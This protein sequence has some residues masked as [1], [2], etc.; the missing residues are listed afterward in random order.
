[1]PL[2]AEEFTGN[3][4][5]ELDI[6]VCEE[7]TESFDIQSLPTFLFFKDGVEVKRLKGSHPDQLKQIIVDLGASAGQGMCLSRSLWQRA[8][9]LYFGAALFARG[10]KG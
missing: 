3:V 8:P 10:S 1:V 4:Y 5:A 7:T 6:D 2:A 9:L